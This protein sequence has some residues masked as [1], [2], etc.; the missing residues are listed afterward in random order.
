MDGMEP[1]LGSSIWRL[2]WMPNWLKLLLQK[3]TLPNLIDTLPRRG[4]NTI[5][6]S[7]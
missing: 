5:L 1:G 4:G 6:L 7:N 3:T 2:V